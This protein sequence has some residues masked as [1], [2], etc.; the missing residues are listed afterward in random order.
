MAI[1]IVLILIGLFLLILE[2]FVF[3]GMSISGIGGLISIGVAVYLGYSN[4]GSTAGHIIL[5]STIVSFIVLLIFALKSNTWKKLSL[6]T[7][8]TSQVETVEQELIKIG[9]KGITTTRLNPIGKARVNDLEMEAQCPG[10]FLDQQTEIEVVK[11]FKTYIVVKPL[12]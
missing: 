3:P 12:N 1:I 5:A 4:F 11:V 2:F 8:V 9:D 6:D 10:N 7:A